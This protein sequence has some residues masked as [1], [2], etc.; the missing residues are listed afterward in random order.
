MIQEVKYNGFSA[1]PSD[2][3]CPDGDLAVSMGVIA[4]ERGLEPIPPAKVVKTFSNQEMCLY[5]HETV[6]YKFDI[7]ESSDED[8]GHQLV[9]Q[10]DLV[11]S[12]L[13]SDEFEIYHINSI[14][15]TLCVHTKNGL[16]YFLCKGE[17]QG[18]SALGPHMPECPISFSLQASLAESEPFNISTKSA[19]LLEPL[20][21]ENKKL[22]SDQV[23]S[24]VNKFIA[25]ESVNKDKFVF[26]FFVRYAYRLYSGALTMHSAPILMIANLGESPIVVMPNGALS[27]QGT[28][29][30]GARVVAPI[31][32]L[33]YRYIGDEINARAL[34]NWSEIISSIDIFISAPIYT[35]DQGGLCEQISNSS[36]N[37]GGISVCSVPYIEKKSTG[38]MTA[39]V[40]V[41]SFSFNIAVSAEYS[42]ESAS[43]IYYKQT[44]R[45]IINLYHPGD[46]YANYRIV[47]PMRKS[48]EVQNDIDNCHDFRFLATIPLKDLIK[49]SE[50]T[51]R[52][53]AV[54]IT[55]G[56]LSQ[57]LTGEPMTDDYNSHDLLIPQ[58]SITYNN[59]LSLAQLRS[60]LFDGYHLMSQFPY[61]NGASGLLDKIN[62][63]ELYIFIQQDGKDICVKH[64]FTQN[65]FQEEALF[66]Y[67][68]YPNINAYMMKLYNT[69]TKKH[70][71]IYLE[72]H[73]FLNGAYYS[74]YRSSKYPDTSYYGDLPSTSSDE[75]RTISLPNKIYTS[76]VNNPFYFPVLGINTV[77][78]GEVINIGT[79]AKALSEGQF[80]QFPLYAF[81][82]DGVWA[83]EVSATGSY[84][85]RQPIT[86]DMCLSSES[87]TQ[88]DSAVLFASDR[89][90][91][92]LSGSQ[93]MC[94][95]DIL[96]SNEPFIMPPY[97]FADLASS[98]GLNGS[99][100]DFIPFREFIKGCR[101]LYD[102]THQHI[103]VFNPEVKYAYVYSLESKQWG[104]MPSNLANT[105]NSYPEALAVSHDGEVLNF[106]QTD[107]T[108]ELKGLVV[109][110]PLKLAAPDTHKTIDTI[111]QRGY[112]QKGHVKVVLYG[113]RD[114][115]NWFVVYSSQ[116]HYLRGFRGTPYKYFRIAL[117]CN[118]DHDESIYSASVQYTPK[119]TNK[120]R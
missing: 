45:D 100:F 91:M 36:N 16:Y 97:G 35:Y 11:S 77:G 58:S 52:R 15:N 101:M 87:I 112:F 99:N 33:G 66:I 53:T 95:S 118:L 70:C 74:S 68:F 37:Y 55:K 44:V 21:D 4:E 109:T 88:I 2:Y 47:L 43:N 10:G 80:G 24:K 79:A 26:P 12:R 6:N 69:T 65:N 59:R 51:T 71:T 94:I 49:Y 62:A 3:E 40:A 115:E 54:P 7:V 41:S 30:Q 75:E 25:D 38:L 111:I 67:F 120:L 96:D 108:K 86:R 102:Y 28:L 84:S 20:S 89:G 104:M 60:R 106:S 103:I 61:S 18:Y 14:G 22:I 78:S 83:L 110:R 116:D 8:S 5:I 117:L 13:L 39:S 98:A 105:L 42:A 48:S 34:S 56:R 31:H 17:A 29:I 92:L 114:L 63:F 46:G 50:H 93:S 90:I 57:L 119:L 27:I 113:S 81:T 73:P 19:N 1:S 72:P 23:L 64:P 82:T 32:T 9:A 85:A 107:Q 76:E